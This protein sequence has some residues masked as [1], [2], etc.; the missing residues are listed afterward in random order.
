M[1][2]GF[3]QD[4]HHCDHGIRCASVVLVLRKPS[5]F[6]LGPQEIPASHTLEPSMSPDWEEISA[7]VVSEENA[8]SAYCGVDATGVS[9]DAIAF[10]MD[11]AYTTET[12]FSDGFESGDT[13]SWSATNP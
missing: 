6:G 5:C 8:N 4:R 1:A 7:F 11:S 12:I 13:S 9:G 2:R 10:Y 3:C